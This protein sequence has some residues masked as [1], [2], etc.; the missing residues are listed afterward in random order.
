MAR[1]GLAVAAGVLVACGTASARVENAFWT[2]TNRSLPRVVLARG[3]LRIVVLLPEGD[4]FVSDRWSEDFG[5][6]RFDWSGRVAL[7]E[8]KGHTFIGGRAGDGPDAPPAY[9]L[10]TVEE[11]KPALK[12]T[13]VPPATDAMLRVGIG[14]AARTDK[15]GPWTVEPA[16]WQVDAEPAAVHFAQTLAHPSGVGWAYEKTVRLLEGG[17]GFAIDHRLTNTGTKPMALETY[18][19]NFLNVDGRELGPGYRIR[20]AIEPKVTRLNGKFG[21]QIVGRELNFLGDGPMSPAFFAKTEGW[22]APAENRLT[23]DHTDA[24]AGVLIEGDWTPVRVHVYASRVELCPE[25]FL[26]IDLDPGASRAWT[27][28]YTFFEG[29]PPDVTMVEPTPELQAAEEEPSTSR[30]R[31][32]R[33]PEVVLALLA[34]VGLVW[35]A[36]RLI[37]RRPA[38]RKAP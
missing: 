23:L 22:T 35:L 13:P 26:A 16:P 3:A 1:Y 25:G 19:H 36:R 17:D 15:G 20:F 31:L 37:L 30:P 33:A 21:G 24:E 34:A 8:W 38:G 4:S 5:G 7:A 12:V 9:S 6:I 11:Y 14:L 32:Y 2:D 18:C 28:T 27:T 29:E 10:G